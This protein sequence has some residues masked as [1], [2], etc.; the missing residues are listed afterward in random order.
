MRFLPSI[1]TLIALALIA[2]VVYVALEPVKVF[3]YDGDALAESLEGEAPDGYGEAECTEMPPSWECEIALQPGSDTGAA[4]RIK[5]EDDG[6]WTAVPVQLG[7]QPIPS[8]E[9]LEAC[10]DLLD[11]SGASALGD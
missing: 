1:W 10:V 3:G 9:V 2:G 8:P 5:V 11:I 4:F 6:C 7:N